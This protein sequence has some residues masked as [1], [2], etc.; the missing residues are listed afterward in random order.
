MAFQ[1][2]YETPEGLTY[3]NAYLRVD[4]VKIDGASMS[5]YLRVQQGK[6]A[7]T[8]HF[9]MYSAPYD[10]SKENPYFQAYS[11]LKT[12]PEFSSSVDV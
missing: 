1:M 8:M 9:S 7:D 3:Q 4:D 12:L 5:F 2:N 6:D 11:H 10:K